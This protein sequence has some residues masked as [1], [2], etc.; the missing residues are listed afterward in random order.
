[1]DT[2]EV[3]GNVTRRSVETYV[4]AKPV[5]QASGTP[6]PSSTTEQT[7][8]TLTE[9]RVKAS[10]DGATAMTETRETTR[11][12]TF[13]YVD[14]HISTAYG[15]TAPLEIP[16]V[17]ADAMA[18]GAGGVPGA[19]AAKTGLSWAWPVGEVAYALVN[20][21]P[22]LPVSPEVRPS[23]GIKWDAT[24]LAVPTNAA[25]VDVQL[26]FA[27]PFA[28]SGAAYKLAFDPAPITIANIPMPP[29]F[30]GTAPLVVPDG[31]AATA[32]LA[33][34]GKVFGP[35]NANPPVPVKVAKATLQAKDAGG[36]KLGDAIAVGGDLTIA[37]LNGTTPTAAP[38]VIVPA[39]CP[40]PAPA[41]AALP[42]Q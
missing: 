20:N 7:T 42:K 40:C 19:S 38:T 18:A 24:K 30:A 13:D 4:E 26:T 6:V 33:K 12:L 32:L 27:D 31:Q 29:G 14:V 36:A 8:T 5:G 37:W 39:A 2:N 10:A 15:T 35:L 25:S 41:T 11:P 28:A 23:L 9:K 17:P 1:V 3:L 21:C 34:F 16:V 22:A